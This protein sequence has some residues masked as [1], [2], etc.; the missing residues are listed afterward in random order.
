MKRYLYLLIPAAMLLMAATAFAGDGHYAEGPC[1]NDA[2][3]CINMIATKAASHGWMGVDGEVDE[4]TGYF[5]INAVTEDSPAAAAGFK[6]GYQVTAINGEAVNFN[7]KEAAQAT[8]ALLVPDAEITFT[9][10]KGH[11]KSK[12][13]AVR[14]VSMPDSELAKMLGKHMVNHVQVADSSSR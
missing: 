9:V 14:L 4:E 13:I 10:S 12:D 5:V 11:G 8:M 1:S 2:Q 7:D 3:A 6:A